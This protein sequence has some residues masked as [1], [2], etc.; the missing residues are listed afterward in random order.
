MARS[1]RHIQ[2]Y[3]KEIIEMKEQ[4]LTHREVAEKLGFTKKQVEEFIYRYKK[5]V[6][7][8]TDGIVVRPKGRPSTLYPCCI[9]VVEEKDGSLGM[10]YTVKKADVTIDE[11]NDTICGYNTLPAEP[12]DLIVTS[13]SKKLYNGQKIRIMKE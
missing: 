4:G 6:Q 12:D 3:E 5:K 1:Y 11:Q 8:L 7:K 13:A 10:E 9:Y 2:E